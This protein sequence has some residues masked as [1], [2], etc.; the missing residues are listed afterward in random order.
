MVKGGGLHLKWPKHFMFTVFWSKADEQTKPF[1]ILPNAVLVK[2]PFADSSRDRHTG[3]HDEAMTLKRET[4]RKGGVYGGGKGW[5]KSKV[6]LQELEG[7]QMEPITTQNLFLYAWWREEGLGAGGSGCQRQAMRKW[8]R[9]R[10][11]GK[12]RKDRSRYRVVKERAMM[13]I[14]LKVKC[15]ER[16]DVLTV[17]VVLYIRVYVYVWEAE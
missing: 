5:I 6:S 9:P 11:G 13:K 14:L 16:N 10:G 17:K 1:L 12:E 4:G 3:K 7:A 15:R 8:E 2:V